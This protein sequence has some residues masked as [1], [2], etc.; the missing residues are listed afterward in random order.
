M[1]ITHM[2]RWDTYTIGT[3]ELRRWAIQTQ[4]WSDSDSIYSSCL[5]IIAFFQIKNWFTYEICLYLTGIT[6]A[7][8]SDSAEIVTVFVDAVPREQILM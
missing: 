8:E 3:L 6:V 4:T 1:R 7:C 5:V 2:I